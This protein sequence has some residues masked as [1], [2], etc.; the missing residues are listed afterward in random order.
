M[1]KKQTTMGGMWGS[2]SQ[3]SNVSESQQL[4][5]N[6]V[7]GKG[8]GYAQGKGDVLM[9]WGKEGD[10]TVKIGGKNQGKRKRLKGSFLQNQ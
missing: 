5:M 1:K 7:R 8:K 2:G 4:W 3:S 9:A 10:K 6:F